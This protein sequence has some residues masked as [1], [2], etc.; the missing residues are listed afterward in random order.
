M[1]GLRLASLSAYPER[2][3]G[4]PN[5][6]CTWGSERFLIVV[7]GL[8]LTFNVFRIGHAMQVINGRGEYLPQVVH[9]YTS[10]Y[11]YGP[12]AHA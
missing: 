7:V 1:G 9:A 12:S 11:R 6:N 5:G 8:F 4:L 10:R 3:C 2:S